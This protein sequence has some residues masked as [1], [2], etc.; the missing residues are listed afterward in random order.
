MVLR[1]VRSL[2]CRVLNVTPDS[3]S[4]AGRFLGPGLSIANGLELASH[5]AESIDIGGES[6][7][8]GAAPSS[9]ESPARSLLH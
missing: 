4:D 7:Q 3:F 5:G 1:E 9:S 2:V 6:T 8:P